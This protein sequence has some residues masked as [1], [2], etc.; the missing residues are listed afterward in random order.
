MVSQSS[1]AQLAG[2]LAGALTT[3]E[4]LDLPPKARGRMVS[5]ALREDRAGCIS[6]SRGSLAGFDDLSEADGSTHLSGGVSSHSSLGDGPLDA[7]Y[8]QQVMDIICKRVGSWPN[9]GLALAALRHIVSP[10]CYN[11]V[12]SLHR[13]TSAARHGRPRKAPPYTLAEGD[14]LIHLLTAELDSMG[15]SL[16]ALVSKLAAQ[17]ESIDAR[18]QDSLSACADMPIDV[19][20]VDGIHGTFLFVL[21]E[22]PVA[23]TDVHKVA[24]KQDVSQP[25]AAFGGF[26][27]AP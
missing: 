3:I 12:R 8:V 5:A 27:D 21:H 20:A 1:R 17:V 14:A 22:V 25:F 7:M 10:E 6:S 26:V 4:K 15:T 11:M 16:V 19:T 18:F 24:E 2:W 9:L 13:R 23:P